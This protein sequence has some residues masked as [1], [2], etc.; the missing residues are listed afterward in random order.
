MNVQDL[1]AFERL[2]DGENGKIRVRQIEDTGAVC[3]VIT[4][5]IAAEERFKLRLSQQG[6]APGIDRIPYWNAN[7]GSRHPRLTLELREEL[8]KKFNT[9][10][11]IHKHKL[12]EPTCP[13]LWKSRIGP[14]ISFPSVNISKG[15]MTVTREDI[16]H[17][18]D[19]SIRQINIS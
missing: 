16:V 7:M 1:A 5:D 2:T 9:Q 6:L 19:W 14:M 4:V 3:G 13:A 11:Q 18:F 15:V 17:A 12:S 8:L 10:F